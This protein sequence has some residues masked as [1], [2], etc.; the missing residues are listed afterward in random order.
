[1]TGFTP[2]D[3]LSLRSGESYDVADDPIRCP[4]CNFECNHL[5]A[6]LVNRGGD[7]TEIRGDADVKPIVG[8][9]NGRGSQVYVEL[10]CE[11]G[12]VWRMRLAFHKGSVYVG[13]SKIGEGAPEQWP[14]EFW[15]D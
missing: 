4:V 5:V 3:F 8:L 2:V 15:R 13:T 11:N 14:A 12:H 10:I 7:I 1:M 6:V 9:P